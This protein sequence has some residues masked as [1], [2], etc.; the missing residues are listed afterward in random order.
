MDPF[1]ERCEFG[2]GRHATCFYTKRMLTWHLCDV[3]ARKHAEAFDTQGW[4]IL[5]PA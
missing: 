3:C 1:G 5:L 2:C 4:K